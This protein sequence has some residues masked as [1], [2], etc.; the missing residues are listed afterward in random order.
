MRALP[1]CLRRT[2]IGVVLVHAAVLWWLAQQGMASPGRPVRA[3]LLVRWLQSLA[4]PPA[5]LPPPAASVATRAPRAKAE[6]RLPAAIPAPSSQESTALP[7]TLS[8]ATVALP[9]TPLRADGIQRAARESAR[10]IGLA[11]LSDERLGQRPVSAQAA[12]SAGVA[13]A[14]QGDCFKGGEGGYAHSGIGLLA[15]PLLALDV[16]SGRCRK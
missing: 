2:L 4:A 16:A 11:E 1:P 13:S 9:T 7:Q 12:L 8:P 15:L 6:N 10:R 5:A 14:A 3:P